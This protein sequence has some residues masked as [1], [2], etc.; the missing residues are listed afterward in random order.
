MKVHLHSRTQATALIAAAAVS[1]LPSIALGATPELSDAAGNYG[2]TSASRIH[3]T[4]AQ[5]GGGGGIVGDFGK[6]SGNFRIDRNDI[7][8]STVEFTLYPE[9]VKT[10]EKRIEDFLKS[11]AVFDT[12][13][14]NTVTFRSTNVKQTGPDTAAVEGTL[15]ARG[16]SRKE[17]FSVTLLDWNRGSIAFNIRGSIHRSPYG[18]DV[19]TPIYSNVVEFDM[20]IKGQRH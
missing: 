19:G 17:R 8:R 4:V 16:T 20:N 6:F 14:Y 3:F 15:T 12:S 7:D 5:A 13:N 1:V 2:I 18:M 9:S 11:S 10:G